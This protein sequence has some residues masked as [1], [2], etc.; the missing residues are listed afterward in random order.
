MPTYL[1]KGRDAQGGLV[2]GAVDA[3]DKTAA[4]DVLIGRGVIP[5]DIVEEAQRNNP[6]AQL[7]RMGQK[8][9]E[10]DIMFF[11]RQMHTLIRA[12]VPI[13]QALSGL[14]DSATNPAF[15]RMLGRLRE[16]LDSGRELSVAMSETG[17]FSGFYVAMIRVGEMTGRLDLIFMRLFE[18]L[19]FEKNMRAKIKAA[20]R[21]P[22]FVVIALGAALI[23]INMM[24]IPAFAKVF[25]TFHAELPL[26][27]RIL[28]GFSNFCVSYWWAM[29]LG[30]IA[31]VFGVRAF[32]QTPGGDL[33]WSRYKLSLPIVG[34]TINKA[35][36]SRFARSFS[37]ALSSGLSVLQAFTVVAQVVDNAWIAGKLEQMRRGVERGESILR[38]SASARIFTPIVL[39]MIAVGEE[40]GS[41]DELLLEIAQMYER[42][43]DY[44]LDNLSARIEPLLIVLLGVMVLVLALGIFLPVW[45]LSSVMLSKH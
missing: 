5:V 45:D 26:M 15:A 38:T 27:T 14:R 35:M 31:T 19:A 18:H 23:V 41:V 43:V 16:G 32:V 9:S 28:I 4:A 2:Q 30:L 17:V 20:L 7:G 37:L 12:G 21:Y 24:V 1:Y 34:T 8:V 25:N 39:Q 33:L 11:S 22:S 10:E 40:S 6:F 29:L 36:L 13:L 44:E 3:V 42:E